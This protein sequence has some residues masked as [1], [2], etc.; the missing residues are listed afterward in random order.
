L[1]TAN[2]I[3]LLP[4][5]WKVGTETEPWE[6]WRYE[7]PYIKCPR[8]AQSFDDPVSSVTRRWLFRV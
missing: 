2:I 3:L 1:C 8:V 4:F 5:G 7:A 6:H